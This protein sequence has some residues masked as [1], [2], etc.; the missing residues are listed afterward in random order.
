MKRKKAKVVMA[1]AAIRHRG[2]VLLYWTTSPT[3]GEVTGLMRDNNWQINE[4]RIARV[5]IKE[6]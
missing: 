5:I 6:V 2:N 1:W 3:R 4:W